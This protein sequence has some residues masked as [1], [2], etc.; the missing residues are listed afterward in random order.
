MDLNKQNLMFIQN[1]TTRWNSMYNMFTHV[2][3]LKNHIQ[4]YVN[5]CRVKRD[6]KDKIIDETI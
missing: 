3:E 2:L 4:V 6:S 5:N 1:N